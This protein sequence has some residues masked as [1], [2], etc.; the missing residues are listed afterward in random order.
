MSNIISDFLV[1]KFSNIQTKEGRVA[2]FMDVINQVPSANWLKVNTNG[3]T[4][5]CPNLAFW[6]GHYL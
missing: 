3:A 4:S 1:L 6:V 2:S 5:D